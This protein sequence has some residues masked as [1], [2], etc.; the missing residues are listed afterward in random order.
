MW[1]M[2][3]APVCDPSHLRAADGKC[4]ACSYSAVFPGQPPPANYLLPPPANYLLPPPANAVL[5]PLKEEVAPRKKK[6]TIPKSVK[7]AVWITHVGESVATSTCFCCKVK[8]ISQMSYHCGHVLAEANGGALHVDNMRPICASCNSSM[9]ATN[10]DD[11]R[12]RY[13]T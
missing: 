7:N 6:K 13:F 5:P 8:T 10:M 9:G 2:P 11:F 3:Q 12:A 1:G 4:F